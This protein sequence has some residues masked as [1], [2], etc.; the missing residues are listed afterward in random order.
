MISGTFH[1]SSQQWRYFSR[2]KAIVHTLHLSQL[3]SG[4]SGDTILIASTAPPASNN[5]NF[6]EPKI[7][8]PPSSTF[9]GGATLNLQFSRNT[10]SRVFGSVGRDKTILAQ[11]NMTI[12]FAGWSPQWR[13]FYMIPGEA[14]WYMIYVEVA[15]DFRDINY[16]GPPNPYGNPLAMVLCNVAFSPSVVPINSNGGSAMIGFF[17]ATHWSTNM[18]I[19]YQNGAR[20]HAICV[21]DKGQVIRFQGVDLG[22]APDAQL[23]G[24]MFKIAEI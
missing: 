11:K 14:G 10:L 16:Q 6:S 2:E 8:M 7:N 4:T 22:N 24:Y 21:V 15:G 20:G 3:P 18:Y 17:D 5:N 1:A 9:G 13:E 23:T 19:S 12:Q